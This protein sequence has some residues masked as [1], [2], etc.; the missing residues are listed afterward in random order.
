M[1]KRLEGK[2]AL[3][4]EAAQG[5]GRATVE[6]FSAEGAYII[7]TD[8]D[9]NQL[10]PLSD[11]PNCEVRQLDVTKPAQTQS[12][13]TDVGAIDILFNCAGYVADGTILDCDQDDWD[14]SIGMNLTSMYHMIRSFLPS[15]L[16]Q[17]QGSIINVA[18]TISSIKGVPNRFAYG[19]TKAAVIGL[20]KSVAADYIDQGIRC[21]AICP[22][23]IDS[24]TLTARIASQA[25]KYGKSAEQVRSD[26]LSHQPLGRL[27]T[28]QEVAQLVVYLA[29]DE[30][31]YTT[32]TTQIIDG[33]WSNL[34]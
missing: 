5:M 12:L 15:M 27:G 18:S 34:M 24:P 17:E 20:T 26:F 33:G 13:V 8:H 28:P 9:L 21:N 19:T 4:T 10:E 22:G 16:A 7:A 2:R 32:G 1:A 29:S 25:E 23:A 14:F 3:V 30:S 11:I 31:R 6:A